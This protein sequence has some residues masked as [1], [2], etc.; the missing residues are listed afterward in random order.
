MIELGWVVT[1]VLIKAWTPEIFL[2]CLLPCNQSQARSLHHRN[3]RPWTVPCHRTNYFCVVSTFI[4]FTTVNNCFSF[5]IVYSIEYRFG[6]FQNNFKFKFILVYLILEG[7]A[8]W[9][10]YFAPYMLNLVRGLSSLPILHSR[11]FW[12]HS[13]SNVQLFAHIQ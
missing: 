10:V 11:N 4:L 13:S 6:R 5:L 2:E 1:A 9:A 8:S 12:Q 7:I 3:Y